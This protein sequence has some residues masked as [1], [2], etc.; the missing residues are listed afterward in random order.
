MSGEVDVEGTC[1]ARFAAVREAFAQNYREHGELGAALAVVLDGA[2]VVDLWAGYRDAART[3]PWE[4]DTIVTV[5]SVTKGAV[6][7]CAHLLVEQGQL[8]VDRPVAEY[9]P[10]FAQ[11]GKERLPVRY[12]LS[13][14]AGLP[15]VRRSLPGQAVYDWDIMVGALAAERPWWEPG[16]Q[17]GYHAITFGHLVGEVIRR[18]SGK[19][20]GRFLRDEIARPLGIDL[21]IGLPAAEE[22]RV[23]TIVPAPP[24][25]NTPPHPLAARFADPESMTFKAFMNPLEHAAPDIM[26]RRAWRAAE[27]PAANG[28]ANAR[29]IARLYGA[30]ARGGSTL[31]GVRLLR[32]GTIAA[33]IVE[34]ARGIDA[35]LGME[36]RFALGFMLPSPMRPFSPNPR[37]FGHSGAGGALGFADPD[38]R[39]G[40]GYVANRTVFSGRGGD[41]RW[42]RLIEAVYACLA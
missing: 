31:D 3:T 12:L 28:H 5:F 6:A 26:N 40:F 4:E 22:R 29:T 30:L 32:P 17:H 36:D 33:A 39:L 20:P 15:A 16:T 1:D 11:A 23:A 13:H 9:W 7:V 21:F 41:P 2:P 19:S 42:P 34:Q 18:V 35:V 25:P 27:I 10:E 24:G 8:D 14:Q 38:A 37:A